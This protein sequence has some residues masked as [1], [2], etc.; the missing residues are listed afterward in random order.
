[1][2][3]MRVGVGLALVAMATSVAVADEGTLLRY[4]W[5]AGAQDAENVA[6]DMTGKITVTTPQGTQS[7]NLKNHVTMPTF[8]RVEEVTADGLAQ[9]RVHAIHQNRVV[10][11]L[12]RR[13]VAF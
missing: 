12:W 13:V 11:E 7:S 10:R 5:T 4:K 3:A 2:R 1:M 6:V 8:V 9:N